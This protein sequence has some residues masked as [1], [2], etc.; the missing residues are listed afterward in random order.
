M[1]SLLA[2]LV[3]PVLAF[4]GGLYAAHHWD[5]GDVRAL[6]LK[7]ATIQRD[8]A[9]AEVI[10]VAAASDRMKRA[11]AVNLNAAVAEAA[12]QQKLADAKSRLSREIPLHVSSS[13]PFCI[14]YGLVRVLDAASLGADPDAL[15]LPAGQS[16]ESCA[17]VT[18]AALAGSVAANYAV[19]RSNAEELNALEAWNT[20][21]G[22][23]GAVH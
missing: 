11:D 20:A 8:D 18:A 6:Q 14:S 1:F 23:T 9:R 5:E 22:S 17:P 21:Q 13:T 19:A 10:A 16:D 7:I 15:S 3:L 4:C 12:A 2:K